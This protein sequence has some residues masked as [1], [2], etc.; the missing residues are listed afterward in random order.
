MKK[1]LYRFFI[2][3]T[4][5]PLISKWLERFTRSPYS[6]FMIPSFTRVYQLNLD[7]MEKSITEY[8]SLHDLFT[9]K[10]KNKSR[11]IEIGDQVVTSPVDGVLEDFGEISDDHTFI[12]KGKSYSISEML[13]DNEKKRKYINGTFLILYLSPSHYH[14]IH[15]PISGDIVAQ[16]SLGTSSYPVNNWGVKYG[17]SPFTKNYRVI[18]EIVSNGAYLAL[19][20]VGA[21]FVNGIEVT[22]KGESI[23]KGEEIGYF[24]F[25]STVIL[26][27]EKASFSP[28]AL[29]KKMDVQI[30]QVLGTIR[31]GKTD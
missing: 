21:M 22:H 31:T 2:E 17:K 27:F 8:Q 1:K 15:A 18:S 4:N 16:W 5:R 6:R 25:G 26:L 12:A 29:S 30:G 9:R 3:L 7:E 19:V 13:G 14:R 28:N 20:K 24:A 11:T 10:L 23:K